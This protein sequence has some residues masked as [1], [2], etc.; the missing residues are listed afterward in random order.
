[1][2]NFVQVTEHTID[3]LNK[4]KE[5]L[6]QLWTAWKLNMNQAASIKEQCRKFNE[7]FKNVSEIYVNEG[8][9]TIIIALLRSFPEVAL[10]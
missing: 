4:E 7:Q 6:T 5:D 2:E 10:P 3:I 9:L 1:M 8:I